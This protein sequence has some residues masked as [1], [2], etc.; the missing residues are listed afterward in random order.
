MTWVLVALAGVVVG[1]IALKK[2]RTQ[3]VA[4]PLASAQE[5]LVCVE[6]VVT[7]DETEAGP[8]SGTPCLVAVSERWGLSSRGNRV[9]LVDRQVRL[10]PFTIDD[11][12][13][14]ARV[15]VAA[16]HVELV[17]LPV[18]VATGG[19]NRVFGA[20]V[21][22]ANLE[23]MGNH[24]AAEAVVRAGDRI[25]VIGVLTRGDELRI[26]AKQLTHK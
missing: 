23:R 25:T 4:I 1:V 15:D 13:G 24:E 20:G 3:V 5:G 2:P 14:K 6:G 18:K 12:S 16:A 7:G 10:A 22:A 21:L 8:L 11:G 19:P 17:T 26:A 9:Q